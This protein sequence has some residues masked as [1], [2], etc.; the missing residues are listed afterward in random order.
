M[1]ELRLRGRLSTD[2]TDG[3]GDPDARIGGRLLG[4]PTSRALEDPASDSLR[5]PRSGPPRLLM[6]DLD[7]RDPSVS[8][9]F[10]RV[11]SPE[12]ALPPSVPC[13]GRDATPRPMFSCAMAV[14]LLIFQRVHV[15][16]MQ[17]TRIVRT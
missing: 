11:R 4:G 7:T 1:G 15:K 14:Y 12:D 8:V 16:L 17:P 10:S 2:E 13:A 3:W 6:L 9:P 5:I